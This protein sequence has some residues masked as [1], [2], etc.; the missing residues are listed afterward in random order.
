MTPEGHVAGSTQSQSFNLAFG[1]P[2]TGTNT[3]YSPWAFTGCH[4][5]FESKFAKSGER[6]FHV[7]WQ[8]AQML[9]VL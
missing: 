9:P 1:E 6:W 5:P 8:F 2:A 7:A 3:E 4:M